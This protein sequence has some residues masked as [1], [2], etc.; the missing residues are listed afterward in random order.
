MQMNEI[1]QAVANLTEKEAKTLLQ[2]LFMQAQQLDDG[3]LGQAVRSMQ[4]SV[5]AAKQKEAGNPQTV[6]IVFDRAFAGALRHAFRKKKYASSEKIICVPDVLSI[7]PVES[8][9]TKQGIENRYRWL[10]A[11]IRDEWGERD[12]EKL[13]FIRAVREISAI[14]PYQRI[15]MWAGENAAE[16]TGLRFAAY[17]LQGRLH[18]ISELNTTRAFEKVH[19]ASFGEEVQQ[20]LMKSGELSSE[21]LLDIYAYYE[22]HPWNRARRQA[23]EREGELLM[24]DESLLR[25]WEYGELWSSDEDRLDGFIMQCAKELLAEYGDEFFNVLRLVG[26]VLGRME[27]Y[28]GDEWIEY[29]VRE[30][31]RQGELEFEGDLGSWRGYRVK[32]AGY[33]RCKPIQVICDV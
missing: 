12:E 25:I 19:A 1:R 6:H 26:E 14:H 2:L 32:V 33:K 8:L 17:L 22:P 13:E 3:E 21:Q 18:D 7:G 31:I 16:Q 5:M 27:Q 20:V 30:L 11:K 28:T 10:E 15:T 29:R 4:E 24:V 23:L 9:H